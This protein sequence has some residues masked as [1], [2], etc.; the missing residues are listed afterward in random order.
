MSDASDSH[1]SA[2]EVTQEMIPPISDRAMSQ[3]VPPDLQA[4]V[5]SPHQRVRFSAETDALLRTRLQYAALDIAIVLAI[6]FVGNFLASSHE[7][8]LLRSIV[9]GWVI[10]AYFLLKS[11]FRFDGFALRAFEIALFGAVA[12]QLSLMMN[13]RLRFFAER[14][15]STSVVGT[16][17]LYFTAFCLHVLTYGIFMPNSWKRAA[18]VTTLIALIPY[19]VWFGTAAFHPEIG[20]LASTNQAVAP[21]PLTLIAALIATFGSHIINRT[22]REAFQAKQLMQ[23]RLQDQI[24]HGGMGK[25]YRAEHTLLKRPCAIK[26]IHSDKSSDPYTIDRF[27]KEVIATAKL[28]HWNTIDIY[29][30][31]RTADGTFFYVMELLNGLSIQDLIQRFGPMPP[32]RVVYL[33]LQACQA[34]HE[35]H[36]AG[37]IHRDVKPAN[38]FVTERGG[39]WDVLKILDFGLVRELDGEVASQETLNRFSGTPAFMAPEQAFHYDTVDARADIYALGAVAYYMLS[40]DTVFQCKSTTEMILAHANDEV[41]PL[42]SP[43]K[44]FEESLEQIIRRCLEKDPSSR[45]ASALE[46]H[47][48]LAATSLRSKWTAK[49]AEMWWSQHLPKNNNQLCVTEPTIK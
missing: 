3:T 16:Q 1:W 30:Y 49:D 27:E 31:G 37:L 20:K 18:V 36:T 2:D 34:L 17:Y 23:Y 15:D 11:G 21:I 46:L 42:G 19:A 22:R 39:Y 4:R 40:G 45:F 33:L 13:G 44:P 9:L 32:S 28:S 41:R 14:G 5:V 29:D 8:L 38:L 48:A 26:L 47:D 25:V 7:W 6:S 12:I 24:G 10:A 43:D 35:A